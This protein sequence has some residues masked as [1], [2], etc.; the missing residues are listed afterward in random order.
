MST[1]LHP[2][3]A[4]LA[5]R[6]DEIR[7]EFRTG[8]LSAQEANRAIAALV[9]RDDDGILWSIDPSSGS[10]MRRSAGGDLVVGTP[11]SYGLKTPTPFDVSGKSQDHLESSISYA[12]V[13][14]ELLYSP[15]QFAGTT[16]SPH[17]V[18]VESTAAKVTTSVFSARVMRI[19]ITVALAGLL[20]AGVGEYAHSS[21]TSTPSTTVTK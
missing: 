5:A 4:V 2:N 6:Y 8:V 9:A 18:G 3:L 14:D 12:T 13:E 21:S 20:L 7:E 11:P 10:W 16:R 1:P 19:I 15:S 17:G